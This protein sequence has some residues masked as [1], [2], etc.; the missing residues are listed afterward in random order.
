MNHQDL[1]GITDDAVLRYEPMIRH[2]IK[3]RFFAGNLSYAEK[4][5]AGLIGVAIGLNTYDPEKGMTV[6]SWVYTNIFYAICRES[7]QCRKTC[8]TGLR[9]EVLPDTG[10][11]DGDP[12]RGVDAA[13][14]VENACFGGDV[15][16]KRERR[17]LRRL[18]YESQLQSECGENEGLTQ[19]AVSK[20]RRRAIDKLRRKARRTGI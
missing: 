18:Y 3:K 8:S 2:V 7:M 20:V 13:D 14:Y 6:K 1:G 19:S 12:E 11:V 4:F 5:S 9:G 10:S 16:T 17:I 15:L